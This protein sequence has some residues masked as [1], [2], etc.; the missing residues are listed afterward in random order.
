M[1]CM[2]QRSPKELKEILDEA[3]KNL[4][5]GD[6]KKAELALGPIIEGHSEDMASLK[7]VVNALLLRA[8]CNLERSELAKVQDDLD[9]AL[10]LAKRAR[11]PLLEGEVLARLARHSWRCGD[12]KKALDILE[13][14]KRIA[15][16]AKDLRLEGLI[17]SERGAVYT[18]SHRLD[19]AESEFREAVLALER[20]GDLREL[21]KAYN[22]FG[23]NFVFKGEY[24]TAVEIFG[25][26]KRAAE[27]A[28]DGPIT[29]LAKMNLGQYLIEIGKF[30]EALSE[31]DGVI[32]SMQRA[33]DVN[34]IMNAN[35]TCGI[36]YAKMGEWE[37][38]EE[39]FF[40]ARNLAQR[41]GVP[42]DE[43]RC[44]YHIGRMYKWRG[45]KAKALRFLKEALEV[46]RKSGISQGMVLIEKEIREVEGSSVDRSRKH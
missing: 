21:A 5:K 13:K 44:L 28:G 17:H 32:P 11:D 45:D 12:Y 4:A 29:A 20:S 10:D 39:H 35:E 26:C 42:Y 3:N 38:A 25:K 43:G 14:A 36:I 8:L 18:Q 6:W 16:A 37:K 22:Y 7:F 46:A 40:V 27:K 1:E 24:K 19:A 34:G 9:R 33:K 41:S 30:K 23:N 2:T 31:M 15:G